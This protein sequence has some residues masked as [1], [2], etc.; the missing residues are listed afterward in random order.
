M[1]EMSYSNKRSRKK[2]AFLY[3][4]VKKGMEGDG[5]VG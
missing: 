2:P 4:N 1:T 5:N 3:E